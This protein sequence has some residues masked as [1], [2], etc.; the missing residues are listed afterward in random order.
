MSVSEIVRGRASSLG[1]KPR[2]S[3]ESRSG[4]HDNAAESAILG[5]KSL[6]KRSLQPGAE[7]NYWHSTCILS[8]W[9]FV[10]FSRDSPRATAGF[11][12]RSEG[13]HRSERPRSEVL[14]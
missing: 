2:N 1:D 10:H 8:I 14:E 12:E 4:T 13:D 9:L 7:E 6:T 5:R 3:G 11:L